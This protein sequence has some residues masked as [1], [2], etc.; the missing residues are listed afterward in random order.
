MVWALRGG[1]STTQQYMTLQT[2]VVIPAS[3]PFTIEV[4]LAKDSGGNAR[5]FGRLG[6]FNSRLFISSGA[7]PTVILA[8]NSGN[9]WSGSFSIPNQSELFTLRFERSSSNQVTCYLDNVQQGGSS[10]VSGSFNITVLFTTNAANQSRGYCDLSKISISNNSVLAYKWDATASDHSGSTDQPVLTDTVG[11]N[12]ATGVNFP[13]FDPSVWIDLGGG[14]DLTITPTGIASTLSFGSPTITTSQ[15][16]VPVGIGSSS[17][18]DTPVVLRSEILSPSGISST[19][20]IPEPTLTSGAQYLT[21]QGIDNTPDVGIPEIKTTKI[22][23]VSGIISTLV[24]GI[25]LVT[26]G[27]IVIVSNLFSS[28]FKTISKSLFRRVNK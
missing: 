20:V 8:D 16:L 4:V 12:N 10:L 26:G 25:P 15:V 13:S 21:V 7:S 9:N 27:A 18:I 1:D 24:A 23:S 5:P 14:G 2:E 11:G 6:N 28:L 3:T 17:I 22:L 19:L